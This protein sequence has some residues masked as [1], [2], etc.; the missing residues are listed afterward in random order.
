[1]FNLASIAISLADGIAHDLIRND[2]VA[3]LAAKVHSTFTSSRVP[4]ILSDHKNVWTQQHPGARSGPDGGSGADALTMSITD[5]L[6]SGLARHPDGSLV[7]SFRRSKA[8][9]KNLKLNNDAFEDSE[10]SSGGFRER[11]LSTIMSE[12]FEESEEKPEPRSK[13]APK[14]EKSKDSDDDHSAIKVR[15]TDVNTRSLSREP[16]SEQE[17]DKRKSSDRDRSHGKSHSSHGRAKSEDKA[18]KVKKDKSKSSKREGPA[19]EEPAKTEE[20]PAKTEEA[21]VVSAESIKK[22]LLSP[23]KAY[24]PVNAAVMTYIEDD[25]DDD[26]GSLEKELMRVRD[27]ESEDEAESKPP[28]SPKKRKESMPKDST[29]TEKKEE[30]KKEEPKKDEPK[31]E[32]PKKEEEP[33]KSEKA[34]PKKEDE[35]ATPTVAPPA[36]VVNDA[37]GATPQ[38]SSGDSIGPPSPLSLSRPKLTR[39]GLDTRARDIQSIAS[40][41]GSTPA[42]IDPTAS[43]CL[44]PHTLALIGVYFCFLGIAHKELREVVQDLRTLS[45]VLRRRPVPRNELDAISLVVESLENIVS[46]VRSFSPLS[47]CQGTIFAEISFFDRNQRP[48]MEF[49]TMRSFTAAQ[50]TTRRSSGHCTLTLTTPGSRNTSA[51]RITSRLLVASDLVPH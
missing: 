48:L 35:K 12:Q 50:S 4:K 45:L 42:R 29:K 23:V 30:G 38:S 8:A 1:M 21:P 13:S 49:R 22:L 19:E 36:P 6:T 34:Q 2:E 33:K 31:R 26:S 47:S 16:S 24:A 37:I 11:I 28:K 9:R 27:V 43:A 44:L 51:V 14:R 5:S 32:E 41:S 25:S 10:I 17:D 18:E 39:R 40:M 46:T 20:G 7:G 15:I 3:A